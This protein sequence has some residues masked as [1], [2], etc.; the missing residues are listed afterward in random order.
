MA[1][2]TRLTETWCPWC[3]HRLD[4]ATGTDDEPHSPEPG[5]LSICIMCASILM[6]DQELIP[7]KISED[8]RRQI[9]LEQPDLVEALDRAQ[10]IVRL[11]DRRQPPNKE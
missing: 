10:R 7:Q 6:F 3:E 8:E 9:L 2:T 5:D 11:V 1:V 4:A